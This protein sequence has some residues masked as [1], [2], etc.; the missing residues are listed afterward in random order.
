M[1]DSALILS[2]LIRAAKQGHGDAARV[3][4][5]M[6]RLST[7]AAADADLI[8][9]AECVYDLSLKGASRGATAELE[10]SSRTL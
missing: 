7:D 10:T 4:R 2:G 3:L 9:L 8:R 1:S 6:V 5:N